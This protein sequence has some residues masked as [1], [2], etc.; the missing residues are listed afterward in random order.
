MRTGTLVLFS[1]A[2]ALGLGTL[3]FGLIP[4]DGLSSGSASNDTIDGDVS[5]N[6]IIVVYGGGEDAASDVIA[7]VDAGVSAVEGLGTIAGG[8]EGALLVT[9]DSG[10]DLDDAIEELGQSDDVL[11]AQPN[12]T[13]QLLE[14]SPVYT[15]GTL[16]AGTSDP[17]LSSQYYLRPWQYSATSGANVLEAW[18]H[19]KAQGSVTIAV[20]DSGIRPTHEDLASNIDTV[21]MKDVYNDAEPGTINDSTSNS[22]G[23]HVAGIAAAVADNGKGIAGVSYNARILPIKVFGDG[24]SPK[25]S[26]AVLLRAF[27]YLAGLV[28]AG[29]LDNLHVINMSL[30]S[31]IPSSEDE[32]LR[33]A[34]ASMRDDHQVLT[35]CAGGNG[36]DGVPCTQPCLPADFDEALAV[37]A[38][39]R[40]GENAANADYNLAKDISA[41]GASILSTKASSDIDY[42]NLGGSSMATPVVSGTAALLWAQNPNLTVDEVVEA[43]EQT[44]HPLDSEGANFHSIDET[45]SV[46]GIDA[47]EALEYI[48][49]DRIHLADV[50]AAS[51][52]DETFDGCAHTPGVELS[53]GGSALVEGEDFTVFYRENVEPGQATIIVRGTGHFIGTK[54]LTFKIV[55]K[56]CNVKNI[57]ASKHEVG[58]VTFKWTK[59]SAFQS[60]GWKVKCRIKKI[61]G[62]SW[63]DWTEQSFDA[64]TY[65]Y[66]CPV[67][68]DYAVE[69]HAK[70]EGDTTYS[71]GVITTPAG[72]RY[73]AMKTTYVKNATSGKRL[74]SD[75]ITLAV[76]QSIR[77]MPDYEYSVTDYAK[78]PRLYPTHAL[79]DL[80]ATGKTMLTITKPDGSAYNGGMIDGVA[81]IKGKKAGTTTLI[82]R[83]PNGRTKVLT[84]TVR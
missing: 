5:A 16:A 61:G 35:V 68:A 25:T 36:Q 49:G 84:V 52:A 59:A 60:T 74:G 66:R 65:E 48:A 21:H 20:I 77:L 73:Q 11:Y 39:T 58:Y 72:G 69:I 40:D 50:Q 44:A 18:E 75:T 53:Y 46:G 8:D 42:G 71:T 79:W 55:R 10:E 51:I 31:Y 80:D 45:G 4:G 64:S 14:E 6:E 70:A 83:A 27:N 17:R 7:T 13:Y 62:D 26:T 2:L 41:P 57:W 43:I 67:R 3:G 24:E 9:L 15:I 47:C 56:P 19:A 54:V 22:H 32:A 76:G 12:Y 63:S 33:Q 23:T 1:L 37:T 29:E 30:G 28:D 82:C 78:R 34:I 38:L 81:T